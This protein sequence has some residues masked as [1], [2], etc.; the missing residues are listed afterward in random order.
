[1]YPCSFDEA[2]KVFDKPNNMTY[3]ECGA[4]NVFIG[5]DTV[6]TPVIIS[7]WKP[8]KEELEEINNTGRIWCF[9]YGLSL[10]PHAIAGNNPFKEN[11]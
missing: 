2:N 9:H 5:Q 6:G 7:C 8:T 1:M 3:E 10:P 4:L 11:Q